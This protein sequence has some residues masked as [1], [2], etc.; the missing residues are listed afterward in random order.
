MEGI[1]EALARWVGAWFAPLRQRRW[2]RRVAI[3]LLVVLTLYG[4]GGFLGVPY[5]LRRVLTG[6]VAATLHRPVT[7]GAIS[8]NPYRLRLELDQLHVG[9]RDPQQP[10]VDLAHLRVKVSWSSLLR[11]A[12][13]VRQVTLTQPVF[14]LVRTGAQAFNFSDL[15]APSNPAP[16]TKVAPG[17]PFRF[18]VSN[19]ELTGGAIYLDDQLLKQRHAVEHIRLG[20]PFIANL[21]S[22]VNIF[23]Q[24]L[25][26]MVIDGSPF[27]LDGKTKPFGRNQETVVDLSLHQLDLP[28]YVAY[29]PVKLPIKLLKGTL[30]TLLHL[31]FI[32]D[33]NQPHI[34]LD[35]GFALDTLEVRDAAGAPL[36]SLGHLATEL[37]E[38][39][40]LE[41]VVHLKRIYIGGL[42]AHLARNA[43]GT[44]NLTPIVSGRA[45]QTPPPPVGGAAPP[46][47]ASSPAPTPVS[48]M[49]P[50]PSPTPS[51][52]AAAQIPA[53]IQL[54]APIP[55]PTPSSAPASGKTP[56]DFAL[57]SFELADSAIEVTDRSQPA[58][59][60][61]TVNAIHATLDNLRT[62]GASTAP[63]E[64]KANFA[65]GGAMTAKGGLELSHHRV[66]TEATLDQ[67]DLPALKAF[68]APFLNGDL[69]G[70]KLSA[71]ASVKTDYAPGAFNLRVEPAS[72]AIDNLDLR[73]V[74]RS[75]KNE[76]PLA[77]GRFAVAVGQIDLA[78]HKAVINAVTADGLK[79][80]VKRDHQGR[81]NLESLIRGAATPAAETTPAPIARAAQRRRSRTRVT[82]RSLTAPSP[83]P[84]P[85]P[86]SSPQWQYRIDSVVFDKAEIHSLDERAAQPV[87]LD[88][89]PLSLNLKAISNDLSKPIT[90]AVDG[91]VNGKGSFK[92]DGTAAP[93][94]LDAK[95]NLTTKR[96][97]LTAVNPYLGDQFNAILAAA[98]LTMNGQITATNRGD[99]LK[100]AYRG[101]LTLGGVRLLDK[102]TRDHFASWNSFS[103]N[104]IVA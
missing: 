34:K 5:A 8:F 23:V 49:Q 53:Q 82:K 41:H 70:G 97:D 1:F 13:V 59:A 31:H 10:F 74:D 55:S 37:D 101:D 33:R 104:R 69:A 62:V 22:D 78:A 30:S 96:L 102:L 35:G 36:L 81:L 98:A 40:P 80:F 64:L 47:P 87:K 71:S 83:A 58:P 45:S 57:G 7:V 17:K 51:P 32:T 9:D 95:L 20:V 56:V 27:R 75:E 72:A 85:T 52:Q 63:F 44:T 61:L 48:S 91:I 86:G 103:A 88:V 4:L 79:L 68:A 11:L 84:S 43:D 46:A 12:P 16:P 90:L 92:I 21:P 76:A 73:G 18:A 94:P 6:Q 14:H 3:T 67:V 89:A 24:P 77:W 60:V 50:T 100:A 66:T 65:G 28:R 26:R 99:R 19:I 29:A 38:V 54:A 15:I 93:A 39:K 25:L 2:I 42:S